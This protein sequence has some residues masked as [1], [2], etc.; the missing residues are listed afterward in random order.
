MGHCQIFYGFAHGGWACVGHRQCGLCIS[1]R[2][3]LPSQPTSGA[4]A[5]HEDANVQMATFGFELTGPELANLQCVAPFVEIDFHLEGLWYPPQWDDY[6]VLQTNLPGAIHDVAAGDFVSATPGV[7]RVRVAELVVGRNYTVT[8]AWPRML[9]KS[10]ETPGVWVA[11]VPSRWAEGA[12]QV[13]YCV[14]VPFDWRGEAGCIFPYTSVAYNYRS[15]AIGINQLDFG[16]NH[17]YGFG[18]WAFNQIPPDIQ[19]LPT[20]S[21]SFTDQYRKVIWTVR[22]SIRHK[23]AHESDYPHQRPSSWLQPGDNYFDIDAVVKSFNSDTHALT[24]LQ[25][26]MHEITRILLLDNILQTKIFPDIRPYMIRSGGMS[27]KD[28]I[29]MV[30][31]KD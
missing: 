3:R 26:N 8:I 16:G 11:W 22:Q 17:V 25:G 23:T 2:L 19:M 30:E 9:A 21:S 12:D 6:I 4:I 31:P 27:W 28:F 14:V 20:I 18:T 5:T 15:V 1:R 29:K 10:G 7:T 24:A 13:P